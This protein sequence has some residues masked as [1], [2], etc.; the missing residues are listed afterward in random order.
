MLEAL[1]K[2][3]LEKFIQHLRVLFAK[4]PYTLHLNKEA[5]YHSLFYMILTLMGVTIDLEVLTDKGRIDGVLELNEKIYVIEF[6][7]GA[8]LSQLTQQAL[9]QLKDKRYSERYLA[10]GKKILLLGVAFS[11]KEIDYLVE[12]L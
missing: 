9:T 5:Y 3:N 11:D 12:T 10:A 7:Y 8:T 6:K 2:E 4:I 1:E